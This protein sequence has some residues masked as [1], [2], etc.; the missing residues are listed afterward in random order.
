LLSNNLPVHLSGRVTSMQIP[1][2]SAFKLSEDLF[3]IIAMPFQVRHW[4]LYAGIK[5]EGTVMR[6]TAP[7]PAKPKL[8][9]R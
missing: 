9:I 4:Q 8:A 5:I 2:P 7:E 1:T 3:V 6:I